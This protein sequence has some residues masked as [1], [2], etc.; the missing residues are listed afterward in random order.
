MEGIIVT[1]LLGSRQIVVVVIEPMFSRTVVQGP[2]AYPK[3]WSK[4]LSI[5]VVGVGKRGVDASRTLS[6]SSE[7]DEFRQFMAT[8]GVY[9][10]LPEQGVNKPEILT[11]LVVILQCI[12]KTV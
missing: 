10:T 4:R 9:F 5:K 7:N 2:R 12:R 3:L 6:T 8:L 11:R 1:V